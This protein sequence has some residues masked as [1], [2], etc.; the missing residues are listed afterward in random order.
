MFNSYGVDAKVCE[1]KNGRY[2][3]WLLGTVKFSDGSEVKVTSVTNESK[4]EEGNFG[5]LAAAIYRLQ[6]SRPLRG[7][8][9]AIARRAVRDYGPNGLEL[10]VN[11][12]VAGLAGERKITRSI[13]VADGSHRN[14]TGAA[15]ELAAAVFESVA[16]SAY[17]YLNSQGWRTAGQAESTETA[18][19][20]S[21]ALV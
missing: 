9:N 4:E 14:R 5:S 3:L 21:S 20:E 18:A 13:K 6:N 10:T 16:T 1:G 11:A 7:T 19:D 17:V 15:Y 2:A 12:V 8:V